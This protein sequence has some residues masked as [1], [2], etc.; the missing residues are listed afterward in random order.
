MAMVFPSGLVLSNAR[1]TYEAFTN[2]QMD[3]ARTPKAGEVMKGKWRGSP[4]IAVG[5]L[6]PI[7]ALT[8]Q[9]WS[10]PFFIIAATGLLSVGAMGWSGNGG[11]PSRQTRAIGKIPQ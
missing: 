9:A 1:A 8:E 10:A 7:F 6:L 3:F 11:L 4:E 2:T 5:L